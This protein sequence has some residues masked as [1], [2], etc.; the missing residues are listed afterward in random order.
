[1]TDKVE[2]VVLLDRNGVAIGQQDKSTVHHAQTPLHL[3]F[4]VYVFA[5]D[6]RVLM[7]RRALSKITWPGVWTNSCCGH[8]MPGESM[9]AAIDRR[10]SVELGAV[11]EDVRSVLPDFA[12]RARDASGIWENEICPVFRAVV[13]APTTI[14]PN[15]AEVMEHRW[16]SWPDLAI[17]TAS[18][19]FA[20]SP[21][22]VE[23]IAALPGSFGPMVVDGLTQSAGLR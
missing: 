22:C 21:W 23:Q 4:S 11:V 15:P 16:V 12:Y 6:G 5:P 7:T 18:A 3:A 9:K 19:P 14:R 8:P 20:F 2:P 10:L 1:M 17:A 13:P